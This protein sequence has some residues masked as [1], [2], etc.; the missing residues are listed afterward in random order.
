[1][2]DTQGGPLMI[3]MPM[4][5]RRYIAPL[6]A[7]LLL[8]LA[9]PVSAQYLAPPLQG[10]Y[11]NPA[12]SGR[13]YAV[14]VQDDF[15]FILGF[16]YDQQSFPT[17]YIVQGSW[18]GNTRRVN[19]NDLL[20]VSSG[21]WIGAAY[22]PP[23]A[24]LNRGAAIVE[25]PLR[26]RMRLTYNGRTTELV[27]FAFNYGTT[28]NTLL[29]GTWHV[30]NGDVGVYFGDLIRID[31]PCTISQCNGLVSPFVGH[32]LQGA[33]QR[34]LV[35]QQLANGRAT[36]LLD[37]SPSY[38]TLYEFVPTLDQWVGTTKT[39]LK[40]SAPPASGLSMVA[41]RL[42][43]KNVS[44][45]VFGA[46]SEDKT[47]LANGLDR[48]RELQ[49]ASQH[50]LDDRPEGEFVGRLELDKAKGTEHGETARLSAA[51]RV[52]SGQ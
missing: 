30:T 45:A 40:S 26:D 38:Y 49:A 22:T 52:L 13:G 15:V 41:S 17:F 47:V 25:F 32:V 48:L 27:Q 2:S 51:L 20:E 16:G 29:P 37:S 19:S 50:P 3:R 46:Q 28:A 31:G 24:I 6:L 39:Y 18:N 7:L 4:G 14:S 42:F 21:P 10:L 35:G 43:G 12:E 44:Q 36:F 1:M 33:T 23:G 9:A 8:V 34:V 11:W 5:N